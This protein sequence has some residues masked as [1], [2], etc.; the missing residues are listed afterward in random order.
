MSPDA[1]DVKRA[2][3]LRSGPIPP[4]AKL[5]VILVE[6]SVTWQNSG[7]NEGG[8]KWF[9]IGILREVDFES[10]CSTIQL[11]TSSNHLH[12]VLLKLQ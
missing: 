1:M 12:K 5:P 7:V 4:D 10:V 6:I 9:D 11:K 8:D 3:Y 2:E